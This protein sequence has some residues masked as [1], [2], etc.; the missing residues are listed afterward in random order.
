MRGKTYFTGCF[1][2]IDKPSLYPKGNVALEKPVFVA[3]PH[4]VGVNLECFLRAE[5][6]VVGSYGDV[7]DWYV[8][9]FPNGREPHWITVDLLKMHGVTGTV[10]GPAKENIDTTKAARTRVDVS[11]VHKTWTLFSDR[12]GINRVGPSYEDRHNATTRYVRLILRPQNAGRQNTG[13][14]KITEIMV[15]GTRLP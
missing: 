5:K 14:P 7:D 11:S 3:D 4:P 10:W 1:D 2:V 15:F 12:A 9:C 13:R 8:K 6:C